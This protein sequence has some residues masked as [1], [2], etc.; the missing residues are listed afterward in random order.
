MCL[1]DDVGCHNLLTNRKVVVMAAHIALVTEHYE[2]LAF[3][4]AH[5]VDSTT[6]LLPPGAGPRPDNEEAGG[7]GVLNDVV[8][9]DQGG[10]GCVRIISYSVELVGCSVY[11]TVG[12]AAP[13]LAAAKWLVRSERDL[14]T[15]I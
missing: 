15:H 14:A 1:L 11:K 7:C 10:V 8:L 2:V 3:L 12:E 13:A 9:C 4:G 6:V 5:C